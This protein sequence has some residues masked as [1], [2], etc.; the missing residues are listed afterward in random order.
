[1]FRIYT[2][3]PPCAGLLQA[4]SACVRGV[5]DNLPVGILEVRCDGCLLTALDIRLSMHLRKAHPTPCLQVD[6][7]NAYISD[8]NR[9]SLP[10]YEA[11]TAHGRVQCIPVLSPAALLPF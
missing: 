1:V 4:F 7:Y 10:E 5:A 11:W 8:Y 3:R 2:P 9:F 6:R